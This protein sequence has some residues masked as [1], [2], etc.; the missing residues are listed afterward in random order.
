MHN[1]LVKF[2]AVLGLLAILVLP[3][4]AF[5]QVKISTAIPGTNAN[6][7]SSAPGA[8]IANFYQFALMIGGIL[9]FGAIVY[10]GVRYVASAGNPS[11]QS[12]GK[13]W[14]MGALIGLLLLAGVY[15]ILNVVN[16]QL[17]NLN[18]PPLNQISAVANYVAPAPP[19]TEYGCV[20]SNGITACSPGNLSDCSDVPNGACS[21]KTCTQ[22]PVSQ[23]GTAA[24][25][26]T[27]P[28]PALPTLTDPQSI[29]MQSGQTLQWTSSDPAVQ[30]NLTALNAAY[31]Q[32][33]SAL[34]SA[35]DTYSLGSVYRPLQYQQYLYALYQDANKYG[36]YGCQTS[37]QTGTNS[38]PSP[39]NTYANN[40]SCTSVISAIQAQEKQHGVCNT[41]S[42]CLVGTPGTC[43]APHT[44]GI[45]I[46]ITVSGP[47]ALSGI[48]AL[49][50]QKGIPLKWQALSGDPVHF[51]LQN[52]PAGTCP[53]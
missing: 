40:A 50:A 35:G 18:L 36:V 15:L 41:T 51:N 23:C 16:P 34:K 28:I 43:G 27:C 14:I 42:P 10:G 7:T 3:V 21:G 1:N 19:P 5:A 17:A 6:S 11:A 47:V 12:D 25:T 33:Q 44:A 26:S 32:F 24:P 49:L 22:V 38:C 45:G 52:P 4:L 9:A 13:E 37:G 48:N 30:Q 8:F 2:F 39:I 29:S 46:D 20:A 31:T 53:N